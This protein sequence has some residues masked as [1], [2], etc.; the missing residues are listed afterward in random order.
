M[1]AGRMKMIVIEIGWLPKSLSTFDGHHGWIKYKIDEKF[2]LNKNFLRT[3]TYAVF[4]TYISLS[5]LNTNSYTTILC[6]FISYC[7]PRIE[8][9]YGYVLVYSH[10]KWSNRRLSLAYQGPNWLTVCLLTLMVNS[11]DSS[12]IFGEFDEFLHEGWYYWYSHVETGS[13]NS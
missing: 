7:V 8:V 10:H 5:I 4:D 9:Q 2:H 3:Q 6:L 13:F 12:K 11:G 1:P